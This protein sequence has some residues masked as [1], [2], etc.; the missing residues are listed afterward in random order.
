MS[1]RSVLNLWLKNTNRKF[2]CSHNTC[3]SPWSARIFVL[4][5]SNYM[6]GH[7]IIK[8]DMMTEDLCWSSGVTYGIALHNICIYSR[9]SHSTWTHEKYNS[10]AF[11]PPVFCFLKNHPNQ[12]EV[13]C[14]WKTRRN[15]Q[16]R[17]NKHDQIVILKVLKYNKVYF[18]CVC[19]VLWVFLCLWVYFSDYV[20]LVFVL[21]LKSVVWHPYQWKFRWGFCPPWL[22]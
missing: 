7:C 18:C 21:L 19:V 5:L 8:S 17:K 9:A 1:K 15:K 22:P 11:Y 2:S 3:K 4:R 16:K 20:A 6:C 14:R 13:Y 12:V 10:R